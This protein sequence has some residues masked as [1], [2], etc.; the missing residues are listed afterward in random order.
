[1]SR[2]VKSYRRRIE[3]LVAANR[4]AE[5]KR[6]DEV[7]RERFLRSGPDVIPCE[8]CGWPRSRWLRHAP[9][10]CSANRADDEAKRVVRR[11]TQRLTAMERQI[12]SLLAETRAIGFAR[13]PK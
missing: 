7:V 6:M 10:E 2:D 4:A 3:N 1:M 11:E 12:D 8:D 5:P 13:R 9:E